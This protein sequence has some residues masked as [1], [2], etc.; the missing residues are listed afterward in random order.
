MKFLFDP[1]D[2]SLLMLSE[3]D[4]HADT[5]AINASGLKKI[6]LSP[7]HYIASI[8]EEKDPTPAMEFGTLA[9]ACVLTPKS[10]KELCSSL[11]AKTLK[12]LEKAEKIASAVKN[13]KI[14][15]IVTTEFGVAEAC[16]YWTEKV[17]VNN[18]AVLI[19]CKARLDWMSEPTNIFPN[20]IIYDLKTTTD[21]TPQEFSKATYNLGYH[22]QAAWYQRAF[23]A[24]YGKTPPFIFIAAEK[25]EPFGI[26]N[27]EASKDLLDSGENLCVKLL[28]LYAECKVNNSWP[29]Y[30]EKI[31]QLNLPLWAKD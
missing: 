6:R 14:S 24:L 12:E 26:M 5:S 4:Y 16:I 9:H 20:G 1:I 3:V 8:E 15:S 25:K 30:E 23:F 27:F 7:A 28:T 29:C 18:E 11:S 21:A 31:Q 13:N 2:P 22:I 19:R 10:V 17:L